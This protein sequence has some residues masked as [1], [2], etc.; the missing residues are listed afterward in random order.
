MEI[1]ASRIDEVQVFAERMREE[2]GDSLLST[3]ALLTADTDR[4]GYYVNIIEF[5]SY[6][7]AMQNS[8]DPATSQL[9]KHLDALLD[10][11]QS[12]YTLDVRLEM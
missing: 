1:K 7:E 5:N 4:P 10:G 6:E 12:F 11:L 3:R 8:N 9:A 2:R